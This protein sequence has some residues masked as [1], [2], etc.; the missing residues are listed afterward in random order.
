MRNSILTTIKPCF[1]FSITL[2]K[3]YCKLGLLQKDDDI[4]AYYA[5]T[6]YL[7]FKTVIVHYIVIQNNWGT[8]M[9][10]SQHM[11]SEKIHPI[12]SKIVLPSVSLIFLTLVCIYIK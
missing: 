5:D 12:P 9:M 3:A 11:I 2:K 8:L 10:N 1:T 7:I 4:N 6:I